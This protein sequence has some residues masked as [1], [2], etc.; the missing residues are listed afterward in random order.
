MQ[1]VI[2]NFFA[3]H[4]KVLPRTKTSLGN[5]AQIFQR[6]IEDHVR[7]LVLGHA[8]R[9][10]DLVCVHEAHGVVVGAER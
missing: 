3:N 10:V 7:Q 8:G 2:S 5:L 6:M 1:G 4:E 9:L